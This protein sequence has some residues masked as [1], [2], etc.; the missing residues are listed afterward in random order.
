MLL[1]LFSN[2]IY[3]RL[4][5]NKEIAQLL[6]SESKKEFGGRTYEYLAPGFV[7][8]LFFVARIWD[9]VNDPMMGMIV[10]N[11]RSKYGK[12][13]IWL[14]VGTLLNSVVF[15]FLFTSCGLTGTSLY[16]YV[17]W[18]DLHHYG[19]TLLVLASEPDQRSP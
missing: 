16:V 3:N 4:I 12:F 17:V 19:R 18:H 6:S 11:T 7:G 1:L 9:A 10:D 2:S 13:R 5:R 8:A 15:I 14:I